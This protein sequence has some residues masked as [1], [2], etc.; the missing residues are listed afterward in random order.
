MDEIKLSMVVG[1]HDFAL[2]YTQLVLLVPP[3]VIAAAP[4]DAFSIPAENLMD[5][6]SPD[7]YFSDSKGT[8]TFIEFDFGEPTAVAGFRHTG[9]RTRTIAGSADLYR[10]VG[11][12]SGLR[13]YGTS[14]RDGR[15]H[16]QGDLAHH[17]RAPRSLAGYS[18]RRQREHLGWRRGNR[19]LRRGPERS[20]GRPRLSHECYANFS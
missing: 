11:T 2:A 18:V 13:F 3:R 9:N 4:A 10:R 20:D 1:G 8:Q 15:R 14:R 19:H 17:R 12:Q 6:K 16:L 5:G 7:Q